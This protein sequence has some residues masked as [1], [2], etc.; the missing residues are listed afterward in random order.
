MAAYRTLLRANVPA[1]WR[2]LDAISN[3]ETDD[4]SKDAEDTVKVE[5]WVFWIDEKHTGIVDRNTFLNDLEGTLWSN[6]QLCNM[7]L[8]RLL[9]Y[10]LVE[11]K[12]GSF[13]WENIFASHPSPATS[14]IS[15]VA[16]VSATPNTSLTQEYRFFVK[17]IRNLICQYVLV[18]ILVI[19]YLLVSYFGLFCT[20]KW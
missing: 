4:A 11:V 8:C 6:S 12:V 7:T 13:S 1:F 18:Q 19:D 16:K 14:P 17:A 2:I 10:P 20:G 5:L 9:K 3:T 15:P